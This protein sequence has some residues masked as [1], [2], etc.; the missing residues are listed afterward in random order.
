MK[1]W[2]IFVL[3]L[4]LLTGGIVFWVMS[5]GDTAPTDET[6]TSTD[7]TE[8]TDSESSVSG[9]LEDVIAGGQALSCTWRAPEAAGGTFQAGDGTLY[10]D[11]VSRGRSMATFQIEDQAVPT[12][13]VHLGDTVHYWQTVGGTTLGFT[14]SPETLAASEAGLTPEEQASALDVRAQY[15]F[16]C[17][18]WSVDESMF[19]LPTDVE[20]IPL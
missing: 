10:T 18:P 6:S 4:L 1:P 8:S 19:E 20:F 14:L 12:E 13:G 5:S 11:G 2:I 3:V 9:S 16:T 17:M 7:T 15:D